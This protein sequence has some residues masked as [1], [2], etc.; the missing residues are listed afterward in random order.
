MLIQN[1]PEHADSGLVNGSVGR[2]LSFHSPT[3]LANGTDSVPSDALRLG[4]RKLFVMQTEKER[5]LE[6]DREE[7]EYPLVEVRSVLSFRFRSSSNEAHPSL[8]WSSCSVHREGTEGSETR[9]SVDF[10]CHCC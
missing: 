7:L 4:T 9:L 6:I 2:V 1:D 3:R 5:S 10:R 8:V